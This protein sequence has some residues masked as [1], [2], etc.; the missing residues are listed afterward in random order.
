MWP[1]EISLG[2]LKCI[3]ILPYPAIIP[4]K[5]SPSSFPRFSTFFCSLLTLLAWLSS[6]TPNIPHWSFW[7]PSFISSCWFS[8]AV[9]ATTPWWR[10]GYWRQAYG[11]LGT[12]AVHLMPHERPRGRRK[13]RKKSNL[14]NLKLHSPTTED[15]SSICKLSLFFLFPSALFSIRK[16][17]FLNLRGPVRTTLQKKT[18][19]WNLASFPHVISLIS[20][21]QAHAQTPVLLPPCIAP[22]SRR[23]HFPFFLLFLVITGLDES[24]ITL[25]ERF[26]LI[27]CC[28]AEVGFDALILRSKWVNVTSL[29]NLVSMWL[30]SSIILSLDFVAGGSDYPN[31]FIRL[32]CLCPNTL[33]SLQD[34]KVPLLRMLSSSQTSCLCFQC[35]LV[36]FEAVSEAAGVGRQ[37]WWRGSVSECWTFAVRWQ[38]VHSVFTASVRFTFRSQDMQDYKVW[39]CVST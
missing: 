17:L 22:M 25:V 9:S 6:I 13:E 37:P 23:F 28:Q 10:G 20:P 36:P 12:P 38:D 21:R 24:E 19:R 39:S 35:F 32:F 14:A 26:N 30:S 34:W 18:K 5:P 3:Y 16:D 15:S 2:R 11:G 27:F 29:L 1:W 8:R 4:P 7:S 33:C 31:N